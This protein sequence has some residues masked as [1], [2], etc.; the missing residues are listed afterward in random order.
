M[1]VLFIGLPCQVT[2]V[3]QYVRDNLEEAHLTTIDLIYY[4]MLSLKM[5][6][7]FLSQYNIKTKKLDN[8]KF[9]TKGNF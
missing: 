7:K 6:E 9:R 5:L 2:A 4:G 3:K 8:I 1:N